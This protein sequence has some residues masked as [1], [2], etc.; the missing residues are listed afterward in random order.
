MTDLLKRFPKPGLEKILQRML[1]EAA[2]E[3]TGKGSVPA[4]LKVLRVGVD[5]VYPPMEYRMKKLLKQLDLIL[6]LQT[7]SGKKLGVKV[8]F[9]ST[10]WDGIFTSL[11]TDKFDCII[12][13]VSINDDRQQN[14]A[15]TKAYIANAQVIVV[16]P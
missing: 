5:D 3:A 15:L 2:T 11:N 12:S 6:I 7:Q 9:V 1:T 8:E 16:K 10:A 4:D 13:S 14:F